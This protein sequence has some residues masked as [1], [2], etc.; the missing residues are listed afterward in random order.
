METKTNKAIIGAVLGLLVLF[1]IVSILIKP[2]DHMGD[3]KDYYWKS[4]T[5]SLDLD[6]Y[7]LSNIEAS[8]LAKGE[9]AKAVFEERKRNLGHLAYPPFVFELFSLFNKLE[10]EDA[11]MIF[12]LVRILALMVLLYTWFILIL[13]FEEIHFNR[14]DL[15]NGLVVLL[16]IAFSWRS[17]IYTD[18]RVGNVSIFEQMFLWL[19][20][21]FFLRK[22]YN[23]FAVFVV[24]A[25]FIKIVPIVLLGLLACLWFD[26]EYRR[27]VTTALAV[28]I[29]GFGLF[30]LLNYLSNPGVYTSYFITV[31][32]MADES[33]GVVNPS[34]MSLLKD[35]CEWAVGYFKIAADYNRYAAV[36]FVMAV[37]ALSIPYFWVLLKKKLY[38]EH[39]ELAMFT[40]FYVAAILPRLKN[41]SYILLVLPAIYFVINRK[42]TTEKV[43]Y[44]VLIMGHFL[45]PY[46]NYFLIVIIFIFWAKE[47]SLKPSASN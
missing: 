42:N 5:Y 35:I 8:M 44:S 26:R 20:I 25:S 27:K 7:V 46:Y 18:F 40:C 12:L 13:P 36:L 17:T 21:H 33:R 4:Y 2:D 45:S 41:Y 19:G 16:F 31:L 1:I 22:K 32:N 24:F 14:N 10:F 23:L 9:K 6:P 47:I 15:L 29:G 34:L 37:S 28:G 11:S 43:I 38:R 3:F 39:M 30:H